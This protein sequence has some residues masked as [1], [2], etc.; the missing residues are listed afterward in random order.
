M[1]SVGEN[2]KLARLRRKITTTMLAERADISRVT[3]RRVENGESGV[4]I[5]VYA[6]VLFCLGLE[7]DLLLLGDNDPLGRRLQDAEL[8]HTK[9]RVP[10]RGN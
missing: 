1:K 3:L 10:K 8:T 4:A 5:G 7:K 9:K 6:S 2:I